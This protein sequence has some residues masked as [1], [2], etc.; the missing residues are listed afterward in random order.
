MPAYLPPDYLD[1]TD[2]RQFADALR[3]IIGEMGE[4]ELDIV[5]GFF[6]PEVWRDLQDAFPLLARLR[7]LIGRAWEEGH[8]GLDSEVD[9][10]RYFQAKLRGDKIGRASCRERVS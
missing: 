2:N 6:E 10:R 9:L 8:G 1:N 7:L 4:N 3:R 5:S